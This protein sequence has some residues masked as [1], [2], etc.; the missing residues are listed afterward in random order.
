MRTKVE[1]EGLKELEAQFKKVE[2]FPKR[3]INQASN[4]GMKPVLAEAK[5]RAPKGE[6][7]EFERL[8]GSHVHRQ[9]GALKKGITKALEKTKRSKAKA[10]YKIIW[11]DNPIFVRP[12]TKE[13]RGIYGGQSE[14]GFYPASVNFGFKSKY[15]YIKGQH[16]LEEALKNN[17]A[18]SQ[19]IIVDRLMTELDKLIE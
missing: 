5:K 9:Y 13:G 2:K 6:P 3:K 14:T 19:K 16:F 8:F 7:S 15:G 17:E 4:A 1:I 10:V 18:K 12:I 11:K